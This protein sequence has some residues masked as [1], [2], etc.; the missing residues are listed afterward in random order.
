MINN[1]SHIQTFTSLNQ[2]NSLHQTAAD[3]GTKHELTSE[4][5]AAVKAK[6]TENNN[7]MVKVMVEYG[8]VYSDEEQSRNLNVRKGQCGECSK[9]VINY[10]NTNHPGHGMAMIN[11]SNDHYFVVNNSTKEIIDPSY[12]Q[13]FFKPNATANEDSPMLQTLQ[14]YPDVFQGSSQEFTAMLSQICKETG[15]AYS[16][17]NTNWPG[18]V[19]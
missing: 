19:A 3:G 10:F 11:P 15:V 2:V 14:E 1:L 17:I 6:L 13:F 9:A 8:V 7:I 12:K 18:F 5:N 16:T 4:I